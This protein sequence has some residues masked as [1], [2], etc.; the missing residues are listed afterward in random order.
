V[1]PELDPLDPTPAKGVRQTLDAIRYL[2]RA[3][4][5]ADWTEG[6]VLRYG[7]FYGPGTTFTPGGEHLQAIADR[8]FPVVGDGGGVWSF[9]HIADTATGT[10]AAIERGRRGI[11][12]V[13]DDDPAP[14]REWLPEI[15]AEIGAPKPWHVPRWVGRMLAGEV[16]VMMMTEIRGASNATAKRELG[17]QPTY[18]TWRG[19]FTAAPATDTRTTERTRP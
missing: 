12:Q 6:I 19:Q 17:W 3:V 5:E 13:V 4:T 10:L 14:V 8:K 15:A 18:P 16:A 1:K 9:T 7:S 11:Y 2:E